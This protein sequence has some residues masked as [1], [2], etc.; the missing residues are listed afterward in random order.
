MS[1]FT[2]ELSPQ[3]HENGAATTTTGGSSHWDWERNMELDLELPSPPD[4]LQLRLQQPY[5]S[6]SP[7][8]YSQNDDPASP[9]ESRRR[10]RAAAPR[11]RFEVV[12]ELG[13]EEVRWFYK[14]DKKTWKAFVG[15]D[16]LR[17]ELMYR[18]LCGLHVGS[19]RAVPAEEEPSEHAQDQSTE[20]T[21]EQNQESQENQNQE[22]GGSSSS[23]TEAVCVRGGLYEVDVREKDCYPVY[24]NRE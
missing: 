17:I 6:D 4:A 20:P 2:D 8:D 7:P 15:H 10:H 5:L 1:G 19:G 12:S 11:S 18:K 13:P 16:S 3:S 9:P 21:C 22:N 24:W 14:E 23:G